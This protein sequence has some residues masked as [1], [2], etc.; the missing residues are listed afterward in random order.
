MKKIIAI[1]LGLIFTLMLLSVSNAAGT[2]TAGAEW[3]TL[4]KQKIEELFIEHMT[5][6]MSYF[7]VSFYLADIDCDDIPE[8]AIW[9]IGGE[10]DF[11]SDIYSVEGNQVIKLSMNNT[12][13]G[14]IAADGYLGLMPDSVSRNKITGESVIICSSYLLL[15]G[16]A[17]TKYA[18]GELRKTGQSVSFNEWFMHYTL[19]DW[20]TYNYHTYYSSAG[21]PD[22]RKSITKDEYDKGIEEYQQAFKKN[23]DATGK[24]LLTSYGGN[25]P[26]FNTIDFEHI[27]LLTQNDLMR[28]NRQST[29]NTFI[30]QNG[31]APFDYANI[32]K[33]LDGFLASGEK[34]PE[35]PANTAPDD[36][37][38]LSAANYRE[39][40]K[41]LTEIHRYP[42]LNEI[43]NDEDL[44]LFAAY[45]TIYETDDWGTRGSK[46]AVEA[47]LNRYFGVE[48][49]N[50]DRSN[51]YRSW[52]G[53]NVD[54]P[55]DGI[56][57]NSCEWVNLTK[58]R[59][60]GDGTFTAEVDLYTS[61]SYWDDS[62]LTPVSQWKLKKDAKI[63]DT[64]YNSIWFEDEK[65]FENGDIY[66]W[67]SCSLT[68]KP[69][70]YNGNQTWQ[71]VSVDGFKI[72]KV[73]FPSEE[74]EDVTPIS[75]EPVPEV[76][77]PTLEFRNHRK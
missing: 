53:C 1:V 15:D 55:I 68:I 9:Y 38:L 76:P 44:I 54:Y 14:S 21:S 28:Y 29:W 61:F 20:D 11:L 24:Y 56:G 40:N 5:G 35:Q 27:D 66:R 60:V 67:E 10:I 63:I 17:S 57:I 69:F 8:L 59:D 62:L 51:L 49:I 31:Y 7:P 12:T 3:K 58:L 33:F 30:A 46:E 73:L 70:D 2:E 71:I 50:H 37:N 34:H 43:T 23:P 25:Y 32:D 22:S 42:G 41:L 65:D 6:E 64:D 18:T 45:V 47:I 52:D 48:K 77:E 39:L 36:V 26:Y 13:V 19:S 4:Y 16:P 75:P 74:L 72:P